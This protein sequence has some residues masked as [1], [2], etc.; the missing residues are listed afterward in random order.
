VAALSD[1]VLEE[2]R[3]V[4]RNR[5]MQDVTGRLARQPA[6]CVAGNQGLA[7]RG[8]G[9]VVVQVLRCEVQ[10]FMRSSHR[11]ADRDQ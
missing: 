9:R 6:G 3:E 1:A 5:R 7:E 2:V 4:R 11:Y 8:H 10:S